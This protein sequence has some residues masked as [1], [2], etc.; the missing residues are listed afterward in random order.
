MKKWKKPFLPVPGFR[1][2]IDSVHDL[3]CV[4][5]TTPTSYNYPQRTRSNFHVGTSFF[6]IN[7]CVPAEHLALIATHRSRACRQFNEKRV[8][9]LQHIAKIWMGNYLIKTLWKC[10]HLLT[11]DLL[12][13]CQSFC[14]K[15]FTLIIWLHFGTCY[16]VGYSLKVY[17]SSEVLFNMY[18]KKEVK[19]IYRRWSF[20]FQIQCFEGSLFLSADGQWHSI[21]QYEFNIQFLT[22][23]ISATWLL[24]LIYLLECKFPSVMLSLVVAVLSPRS[25]LKI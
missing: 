19:F 15:M 5:R 4:T 12:T 21:K 3:L 2:F 6:L 11:A 1:I 25:F 8:V 16:S 17:M 10:R 9:P 13:V 14:C 22:S 23:N 7:K 18:N 20:S 24:V